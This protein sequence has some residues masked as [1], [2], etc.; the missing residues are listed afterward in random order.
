VPVPE[1]AGELVDPVAAVEVA[2]G[3]GVLA[4]SA[5]SS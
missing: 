3:S 1:G 4:A 2:G 5:A